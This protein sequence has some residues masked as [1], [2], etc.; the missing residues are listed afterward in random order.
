MNDTTDAMD[1]ANRNGLA[2]AVSRWSDE[3][4]RRPLI[5]VHRRSLD[6]TWRQVIRYF[7]GDPEKLLGLSHDEL[8]ARNPIPDKWDSC[9][10]WKDVS[11]GLWKLLDNIDTLDDAC[12]SDDAAFRKHT[13]DQQRK[14]FD[15]L[16]GANFDRATGNHTHASAEVPPPPQ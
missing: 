10:D 4:S 2:W 12:R 8:L 15:V 7:G 3:V 13:R 5:N 9:I 14:R 16:S 1:A 6:D 11:V